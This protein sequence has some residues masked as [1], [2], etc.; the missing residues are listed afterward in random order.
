MRYNAIRAFAVSQLVLDLDYLTDYLLM[1]NSK[2]TL[3]LLSKIGYDITQYQISLE[4]GQKVK[5]AMKMK[6]K[7][8]KDPIISAKGIPKMILQKLNGKS[9][10]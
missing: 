3:D 6:L 4:G 2:S 7:D 8:M 5:I 1:D 10:N 9:E